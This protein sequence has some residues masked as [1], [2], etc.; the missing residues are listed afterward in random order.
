MGDHNWEIYGGKILEE[1]SREFGSGGADSQ[2]VALSTKEPYLYDILHFAR[3]E[4]LDIQR[5]ESHK[6]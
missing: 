5:P 6:C 2:L 4:T 3:V 1:R